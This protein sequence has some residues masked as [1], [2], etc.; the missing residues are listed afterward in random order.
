MI[1]PTGENLR[2]LRMECELTQAQMATLMGLSGIQRISEYERGAK[3]IDPVRWELL[4]IKTGKHHTY[5]P[6][7]GKR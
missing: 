3:P 4:L 1:E 7:K 5:G 6:L 2:A